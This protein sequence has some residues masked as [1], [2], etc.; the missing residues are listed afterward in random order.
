MK[1]SRVSLFTA[2]IALA[3]LFMTP[4]NT[5]SLRAAGSGKFLVYIGTYTTKQ[6]SK[7]IYAY[8]F[9]SSTGQ[10]TSLG[11]AAESADPSFVAVHPN[12]KYLCAV[13]E[14]DE[15]A[16]QQSGAVTAFPIDRNT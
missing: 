13:N 4:T 2:V 5:P 11:L 12:G 3:V 7:G 9:D 10:L 1:P 16:G 6:S 14:D 15:F 8:R